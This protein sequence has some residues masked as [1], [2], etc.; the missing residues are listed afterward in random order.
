[1]ALG[2]LLVTN[3]YSTVVTKYDKQNKNVSIDL[4]V[5]KDSTKSQSIQVMTIILYGQHTFRGVINK[6]VSNPPESPSDGETYIIGSSS[7]GAWSE[8]TNQIATWVSAISSWSFYTALAKEIC[9]NE[10]DSKY[11]EWTG[12]SW[13]EA[14][15][16]DS[17][18]FNTYFP[19]TEIGGANKDILKATYIYLKSRPEFSSCTDV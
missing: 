17:R 2:N 6:D 19:M 7:T 16:F 9:Y 1:M 10:N 15:S 18:V 14:V 12:S 8:K 11:Y 13:L 4:T 5:W 3:S